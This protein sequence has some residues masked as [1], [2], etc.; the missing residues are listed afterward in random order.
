MNTEPI[1]EAGDIASHI[2]RELSLDSDT[3]DAPDVGPDED[4][5][6]DTALAQLLSSNIHPHLPAADMLDRL[7]DPAPEDAP[8]LTFQ[9]RQ[10]LVGAVAQRLQLRQRDNG[11]LPSVLRQY[12]EDLQSTHES[13]AHQVSKLT[14]AL[15]NVVPD[16]PEEGTLQVEP[17]TIRNIENGRGELRDPAT[18][19]V[20]ALWASAAG[21][22]RTVAQKAFRTS[23]ETSSG[24]PY[25]LGVAAGTVTST[26]EADEARTNEQLQQLFLNAYDAAQQATKQ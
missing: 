10:H 3:D 25:V 16:I 23:L 24:D 9:R 12:R 18:A 19:V 17:D 8:S 14:L 7:V 22:P 6:S 2:R 26:I 5:T 13:T 11:L 4:T 1:P 15:K 21:V 20:A